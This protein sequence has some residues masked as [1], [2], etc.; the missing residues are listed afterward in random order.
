M[1]RG[2]PV[3]HQRPKDCPHTNRPEHVRNVCYQCS[4]NIN[5]Q[6]KREKR[7]QNNPAINQHIPAAF[8]AAP[9]MPEYDAIPGVGPAGVIRS[10]VTGHIVELNV[11][12]QVFATSPAL[13][14]RLN[15][16]LQ[17][18][19]EGRY[20]VD[21]DPTHFRWILNFLRDGKIDSRP[22]DQFHL[23]ELIIEARYYKIP[24]LIS[25]LQK[26]TFLYER[27]CSNGLFI[28]PLHWY[29]LIGYFES[30]GI[31]S[32]H[33]G[34]QFHPNSSKVTFMAVK[35]TRPNALIDL[36]L[37]EIQTTDLVIVVNANTVIDIENTKIYA[38]FM[39][40]KS[41]PSQQWPQ[42]KIHL[43]TQWKDWGSFEMQFLN[44]LH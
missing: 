35:Y 37:N 13:L 40:D 14:P 39:W 15:I 23:D 36:E 1:R 11:G 30:A 6:K 4:S 5:N 27:P 25:L 43:K 42:L 34:V 26:P 32:G 29:T 28:I 2:R 17:S 9:G 24:E 16:I 38:E 3:K 10:P 7:Y 31:H 21:R 44:L 8:S 19:S 22:E 20:F 12:G 33:L 41:L 18:D